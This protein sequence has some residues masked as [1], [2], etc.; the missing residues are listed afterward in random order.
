MKMNVRKSGNVC[1]LEISGKMTLG[2]PTMLLSSKVKQL[3]AEG[4]RVFILDMAKVPWMD[5]SSIGEVVACRNRVVAAEGKICAVLNPKM[6]DLFT[7][8]ELQRVLKY[9]DSIEK[10]LASLVESA[11]PV[12]A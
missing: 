12:E 3:L 8:F 4:E 9:Y 2:D 6:H 11:A 7:L 10:A 5:S 1:I